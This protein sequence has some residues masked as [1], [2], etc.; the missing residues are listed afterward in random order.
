MKRKEEAEK[1]ANAERWLITYADLMNNLLIFFIMLYAMSATDLSKFKTL[2]SSFSVTFNTD[3]IKET[4]YP[5]NMDA[6]IDS[7]SGGDLSTVS[8]NTSDDISGENSANEGIAGNN[9]ND[10]SGNYTLTDLDAFITKIS[11]LIKNNGYS[12]QISV[13]KIDDY[14]YFRFSEG[15][16]FHP[17]QSVL[18][19]GS[20]NALDLIG[21]IIYQTY[22]E[23]SYI[24]IAGHTS[25]VPNDEVTTNFGSWDLSSD[26]S[27]TVLKFLV[28]EC[29][30]PKAKMITM[31]YSSTQP[32]TTGKTEED[33]ALN[34]RVEIRISRLVDQDTSKDTSK[35]GNT[36]DNSETSN[37]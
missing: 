37:N 11:V 8:G 4:S 25:W 1:E 36:S 30:L 19:E 23:I 13:E 32:Y 28:T 18:K 35:D 34:R 27:M 17:D 20:Y 3:D 31:G 33:K 12:D 15:V 10:G 14:V 9:S 7:L 2:I 16:L 5:D 21:D 6:I 26:R 22:S 29:G 24:E